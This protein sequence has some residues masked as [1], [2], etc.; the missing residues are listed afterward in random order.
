M[1]KR[2]AGEE[3]GRREIVIRNTH[4]DIFVKSIEGITLLQNNELVCLIER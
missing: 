4:A 3:Q 2:K 1:G